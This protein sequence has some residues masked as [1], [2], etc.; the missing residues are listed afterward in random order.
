MKSGHTLGRIDN[1]A[2]EIQER[3]ANCITSFAASRS[4]P[5]S[6]RPRTVAQIYQLLQIHN[7]AHGAK[8]PRMDRNVHSLKRLV[9]H[10]EEHLAGYRHFRR[11]IDR[12]DHLT[13]DLEDAIHDLDDHAFFGGPVYHTRPAVGV[14]PGG[15][16]IG[17][18]GF[19]FTIGAN[20]SSPSPTQ[21]DLKKAARK[22]VSY[23]APT[24]G[25]G[26]LLRRGGVRVPPIAADAGARRDLSS[27]PRRTP[28]R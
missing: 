14:S 9:H 10:T 6:A 2:R 28:I 12:L 21:Q 13:H 15:V 19:S 1:L 17:G 20:E 8:R 25:P 26:F 18:R 3:A 23:R 16:T 7:A 27:S 11:H 4:Q 5:A 24:E 22:A